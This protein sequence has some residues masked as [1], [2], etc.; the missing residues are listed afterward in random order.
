MKVGIVGSGFVGATAAYALVLR[1][2]ASDI[3]LV[4]IN[5]ERAWAEAADISHAVP[6]IQPVNVTAGDYKDLKGSSV[7]IITA[8]VSQKSGETRLQLLERNAH[9]L[10]QIIPEVLKHA[11]DTL[12]L[13]TTN[14][15][16]VMT[17]LAAHYAREYGVPSSR[18][19]GSGTTLDTA[20]F[21][22]LLGNHLRVDPQ[23]VHGYVL[24]E[25]GDSEVLTWS[26]V[27]IGGLPLEKFVEQC[28]IPLG[29]ET[30][31]AID[32]DVR[33]AAYHIIEGKGATYYGVGMALARIVEVIVRDQRAILT[34][35]TPTDEVVGVKDVTVSLPRLTGGKGIIATLPLHLSAPETE[36]LRQSAQI[37]REAIDAVEH[38]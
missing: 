13:L 7:V 22:A 25:H 24:G 11:P 17:H 30:R 28:H 5:K 18:V 21:R 38:A 2:V 36:A 1:R 12:L 35:C 6:F 10:K 26:I 3:V 29:E 37:I 23:H 31:L 14:P 9:I 20:R 34:V 4:D 15:V 19:I 8:G 33:N 16:D 27:D 32:D